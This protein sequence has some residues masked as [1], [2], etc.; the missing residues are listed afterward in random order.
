MK[1]TLLKQLGGFAAERVGSLF[2]KRVAAVAAG[3][4]VVAT[5]EPVAAGWLIGVYIVCETAWK[6][7]KYYVDVRYGDSAS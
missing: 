6:G 7:W 5:Q 2:S 1:G 4:G 3:A